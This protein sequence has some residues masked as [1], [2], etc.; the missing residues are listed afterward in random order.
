MLYMMLPIYNPI[1]IVVSYR[2][3]LFLQAIEDERNTYLVFICILYWVFLSNLYNLL[4]FS[5]L[6]LY[7]QY[8]LPE[9]SQAAF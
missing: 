1:C 9:L 7:D 6:H 4:D 8:I 3:H 2:S 5:L